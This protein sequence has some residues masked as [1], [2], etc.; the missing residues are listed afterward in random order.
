MKKW[1][2]RTLIVLILGA[3]GIV[4][5][6]FR[7]ALSEDEF[8]QLTHTIQEVQLPEHLADSDFSFTHTIKLH[9]PHRGTWFDGGLQSVHPQIQPAEWNI[10]VYCENGKLKVAAEPPEIRSDMAQMQV[11]W[12]AGIGDV[13][14]V[15]RPNGRTHAEYLLHI[16]CSMKRTGCF[17]QE[18]E[19]EMF[20]QFI[21]VDVDDKAADF[22]T[23]LL[24]STNDPFFSRFKQCTEGPA[25]ELPARYCDSPMDNALMRIL[26]MLAA[27][28]E[29][30]H[31]I[32][33]P[34]I[35][36]GATQLSR[37]A[38]EAAWP[39][40]WG[41]A[42]ETASRISYRVG[43]TLLY[44]AENE[45]F[46]NQQLIDFINGPVFAKVFGENFSDAKSGDES[47]VLEGVE[48]EIIR[49]TPAQPQ[50]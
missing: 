33:T 18:P 22:G 24:T 20:I 27:C 35:I 10:R 39:D 40:C 12:F 3:L 9:E 2:K 43:P 44:L 5:L 32:L 48:I 15:R 17:W 23:A 19:R 29:D 25:P 47:D 26:H 13:S 8:V 4:A 37:F 6:G 16:G 42:S 1:H 38:S 7:P 30:T 14:H 11:S 31:E 34:R 45:C 41:A 28:T 50:E 46:G 36:T 49:D 21:T